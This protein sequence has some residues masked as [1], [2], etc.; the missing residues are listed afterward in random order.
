MVSW[1]RLAANTKSRIGGGGR[2]NY[3]G[4]EPLLLSGYQA[5][6]E[7]EAKMSPKGNPASLKA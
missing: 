4:A 3:A 5:M 7:H 6:N 2:K 1:P